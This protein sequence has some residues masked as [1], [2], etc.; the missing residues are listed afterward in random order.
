MSLIHQHGYSQELQILQFPYDEYKFNIYVHIVRSS[1]GEGF[2]SSVASTLLDNLNKYYAGSN[3]SFTLLGNDFINDD[4]Y[5]LMSYY[6][7]RKK[8]ANGLFTINSHSNAIDIYI[9]SNGQNLSFEKNGITYILME[10]QQI[11]LQQ[12]CFYVTTA[13][14]QIR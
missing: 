12:H 1:K 9:I 6:D 8:N 3:I 10:K 2:S 5:N 13:T 14:I 11:F 7:T 4:K